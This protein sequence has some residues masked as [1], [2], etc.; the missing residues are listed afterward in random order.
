MS[1]PIRSR[2]RHTQPGTPPR[3]TSLQL[4]ASVH[5]SE[6]GSLCLDMAPDIGDLPSRNRRDN[7]S[8]YRRTRWP[9]GTPAISGGCPRLSTPTPNGTGASRPLQ[10][11][12]SPSDSH[13]LVTAVSHPYAVRG[14]GDSARYTLSRMSRGPQI[15]L[16]SRD[17]ERLAAFHTE[18]GFRETF[19][20]R[21][22]ASRS[23]STSLSTTM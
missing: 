16:F 10:V 2:R 12:R 15:M 11:I 13:A 14:A 20:S 5:E 1:T 17:V 9:S 22:T 19:V 3:S 23:T 7:R 6:G 18:L 21:R 4:H 8:T